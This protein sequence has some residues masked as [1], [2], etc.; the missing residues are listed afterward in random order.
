MPDFLM[1]AP[2]L[3]VD[4]REPKASAPVAE[5][6]EGLAVVVEVGLPKGVLDAKGE[7]EVGAPGGCE[8]LGTGTEVK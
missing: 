6:E 4:Q 7:G 1:P 2:A 8:G 3:A 5:E